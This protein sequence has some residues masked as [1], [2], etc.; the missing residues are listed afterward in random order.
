MP[1]LLITTH[2]RCSFISS[3]H[4]TNKRRLKCNSHTENRKPSTPNITKPTHICGTSHQETQKRRGNCYIVVQI[5]ILQL[6]YFPCQP[7]QQASMSNYFQ[8]RPSHLFYPIPVRHHLA[9]S[10]L[11]SDTALHNI[12]SYVCQPLHLKRSIERF[13]TWVSTGVTRL[14]L[15]SILYF[16]TSRNGYCTPV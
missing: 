3:S 1:C 13:L 16:T 9:R 2:Y 12:K 14:N 4:N 11:I 10:S 6:K 8:D 5:K 7:S 15:F